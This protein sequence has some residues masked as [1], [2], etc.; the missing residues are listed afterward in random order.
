MLRW[1]ASVPAEKR[2]RLKLAENRP[3]KVSPEAIFPLTR[4]LARGKKWAKV[5]GRGRK[6]L[7]VA[8]LGG[9]SDGSDP[10]EL[11]L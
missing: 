4:L 8:F 3:K 9:C 6:G 10:P 2:N 11:G 7:T 5:G 1:Q